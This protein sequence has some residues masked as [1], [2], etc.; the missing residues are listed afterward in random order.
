MYRSSY[1]CILPTSIRRRRSNISIPNI[2]KRNSA[3][4]VCMA[5]TT[6][7]STAFSAILKD[8]VERCLPRWRNF[9]ELSASNAST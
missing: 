6:A 3:N 8:D 7:S 4:Q 5:T 2:G 1:R 9:I